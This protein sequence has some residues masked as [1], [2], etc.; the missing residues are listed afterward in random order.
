MLA[1]TL[2]QGGEVQDLKKDLEEHGINRLSS[3]NSVPRLVATWALPVQTMGSDLS[4][5]GILRFWKT[6]NPWGLED[7]RD[8]P[9]SATGLSKIRVRV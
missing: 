8:S 1:G 2:L 7:L 3:L 4:Q 5:A 9:I 6:P